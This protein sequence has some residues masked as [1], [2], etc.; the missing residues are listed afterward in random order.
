MNEF[1]SFAKFLISMAEKVGEAAAP[2]VVLP[3]EAGLTGLLATLQDAF[4][5][6]PWTLAY[7][8]GHT[9]LTIVDNHSAGVTQ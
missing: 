4:K 3:L 9:G 5:D 6:K 8:I 7:K 2:E 1:E